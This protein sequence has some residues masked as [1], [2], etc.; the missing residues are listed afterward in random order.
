MALLRIYK[1]ILRIYFPLVTSGSVLY[2]MKGTLTIYFSTY[3][4]F[5]HLLLIHQ[6]S[7]MCLDNFI[8]TT[9]N[10]ACVCKCVFIHLLQTK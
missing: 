8:S 2:T 1:A 6:D 3:Y 4:L 10:C 9:H 7:R 5:M